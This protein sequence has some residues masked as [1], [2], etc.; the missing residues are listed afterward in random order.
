MN[1]GHDMISDHNKLDISELTQ[2]RDHSKKQ[3]VKI[4]K[5]YHRIENNLKKCVSDLKDLDKKYALTLKQI[6]DLK[7]DC[8]LLS[9]KKSNLNNA[10]MLLVDDIESKE[11]ELHRLSTK[12]DSLE[13]QTEQYQKRIK[14]ISTTKNV[15][16]KI[17]SESKD[18]IQLLI[19]EKKEISEEIS[20]RLSNISS[21][22]ES[23]EEQ[24]NKLNEQF[25]SCITERNDTSLINSELKK[26]FNALSNTK[27]KDDLK[28][29][30]LKKAHMQLQELE[31]LTDQ[32]DALKRS[33]D[34]Q[35]SIWHAKKQMDMDKANRLDFLK[36]Q[37]KNKKQTIK[38]LELEVHEFDT[39][40]TRY[41]QAG[42]LYQQEMDRYIDTIEKIKTIQS[43]MTDLNNILLTLDNYDTHFDETIGK[44]IL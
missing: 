22:K 10:A 35:E 13:R 26:T 11:N 8:F 14:E 21:E 7:N 9:R 37:Q 41:E 39:I 1:K 31:K 6:Q 12:R 4:K 30:T 33:H 42:R 36:R 3:Y 27:E 17:C 43:D 23:M 20:G 5:T 29:Q 2:K 28:L 34:H 18:S 16:K 40:S 44:I 32:Y 38:E 15:Q 19:N 24:L 25:M